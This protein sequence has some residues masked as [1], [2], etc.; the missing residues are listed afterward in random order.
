[1]FALDLQS[2]LRSRGNDMSLANVIQAA[3]NE[4]TADM[5]IALQ[6]GPIVQELFYNVDLF[7]VSLPSL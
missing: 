7:V 1:M 4:V 6:K 5:Q 2:E 3:R